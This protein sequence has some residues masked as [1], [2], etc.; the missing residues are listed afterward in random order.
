MRLPARSCSTT[1][2]RS[3][4]VRSVLAIAA[5]LVGYMLLHTRFAAF[6]ARVASWALDLLGLDVESLRSGT[7]WARSDE[8]FEVYAVVTG[9]CS[10]AA[11]VLGV[12]IVSVVLLPGS[13]ARRL[14][15]GAIAAGLFLAFNVARICTIIL[16][17]WWLS[18]GAHSVVLAG[19]I[20]TAVVGLL[21]AF[22][23]HRFLMTR[24]AG[25]LA[26]GLGAV[27]AIDV[28]TGDGYL[29]AMGS[30][31]ALA[32]PMLTFG[33]LALGM[34]FLWRAVVGPSVD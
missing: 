21:I 8:T 13:L 33:G 16:L 24:I 7:I 17:G 27:L 12:A 6:D 34:L 5:V 28:S 23:P 14:V 26:G 32:G 9:S 20:G 2:L 1:A 29:D 11:G 30:Y 18:T 25:L 15:G 3:M 4:T 31:H 19:L 22:A 10:S